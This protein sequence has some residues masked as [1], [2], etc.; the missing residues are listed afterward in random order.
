MTQQTAFLPLRESMIDFA[1]FLLP[2][3]FSVCCR[4][5]FV[6]AAILPNFY[7]FGQSEGDQSLPPDDDG[8]SGTVPISIPFPFFDQ[9]HDSLFVSI[10]L[11]LLDYFSVHA[12]TSLLSTVSVKSV[13]QLTI[14]Y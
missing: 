9:N 11:S 1:A 7:P 6:E 2:L 14:S 8:S 10:R 4:F 13:G 3:V 12:N 5:S